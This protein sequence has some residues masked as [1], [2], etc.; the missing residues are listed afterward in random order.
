VERRILTLPILWSLEEAG[1]WSLVPARWELSNTA[2]VRTVHGSYTSHVYC[3]FHRGLHESTTVR[4][5]AHSCPY[6]ATQYASVLP[7]PST[8]VFIRARPSAPRTPTSSTPTGG[9][10]SCRA[11]GRVSLAYT[12]GSSV[13]WYAPSRHA[14][15]CTRPAWTGRPK[16]SRLNHC[17]WT[18]RRRSNRFSKTASGRTTRPTISCF[19]DGCARASTMSTAGSSNGSAT[20]NAS[21]SFHVGLFEAHGLVLSAVPPTC[22]LA[23]TSGW[24][25]RPALSLGG[26]TSWPRARLP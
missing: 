2:I 25:C 13:T 8:A 3:S 17:D 9:G 19:A 7:R 18:G 16:G 22:T 10:H 11:V 6:L 5:R 20:A 1:V 21:S 15:R 14:R 26:N 12:A 24:W 23:R 4:V